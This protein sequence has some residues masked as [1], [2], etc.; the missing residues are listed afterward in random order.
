MGRKGPPAGTLLKTPPALCYTATIRVGV[1]GMLIYDVDELH[2]A[3]I[4]LLT[5]VMA[6]IPARFSHSQQ[7]AF[8]AAVFEKLIN[9]VHADVPCTLEQSKKLFAECLRS[10]PLSSIPTKLVVE[11]KTEVA[12]RLMSKMRFNLHNSSSRI[13]TIEPEV[14]LKEVANEIERCHAA[15]LKNK[16]YRPQRLFGNLL[17]IES[18]DDN[19]KILM[20]YY[21]NLRDSNKMYSADPFELAQYVDEIVRSAHSLQMMLT[22]PHCK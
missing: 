21:R 4:D 1:Q 9:F 14:Q 5:Q 16:D 11:D 10:S 6:L 19:I 17:S 18:D 13:K 15:V 22:T 7:E 3:A 2:T 12:K 8:R 20:G